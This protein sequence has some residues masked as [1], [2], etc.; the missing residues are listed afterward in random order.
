MRVV[1]SHKE[2]RSAYAPSAADAEAGRGLRYDGIYKIVAAYRRPGAQLSPDGKRFLVCRYVFVR[3]DNSPA[4]WS[5]DLAGGDDPR[6][7]RPDAAGRGWTADGLPAAAIEDMRSAVTLGDGEEAGVT[8]G[9]PV[10]MN[11][12]PLPV[13]T[14]PDP[15]NLHWDFDAPAKKWGWLRP[16]PA[17][18]KGDRNAAPKARKRADGR[19]GEAKALRVKANN[20]ER[21]LAKEFTCKLCSGVLNQPLSMPCGHHFCGPC[22]EKN[23]A[24]VD[25]AESAAA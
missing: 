10:G 13:V 21:A 3:C 12:R 6:D 4:P 20:A 24:G 2:K 14:R 1:R 23:F 9:G 8:V 15:D 11:G 5:E 22:L 16:Q 19:V 25:A 17:S 7:R 18:T